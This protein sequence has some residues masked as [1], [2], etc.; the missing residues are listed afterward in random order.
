MEEEL[1]SQ[2]YRWKGHKGINQR[3]T[4]IDIDEQSYKRVENFILQKHGKAQFHSCESPS[5]TGETA[6]FLIKGNVVLIDDIGGTRE[7]TLTSETPKELEELAEYLDLPQPT[8]G[9]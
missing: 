1:P 5:Y 6:Y 7:I 9:N 4:P 2:L 8:V 3:A